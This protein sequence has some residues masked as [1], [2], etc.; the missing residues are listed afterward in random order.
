[1]RHGKIAGMA[2]ALLGT[3]Q[4]TIAAIA[5][6]ALGTIDSST[7]LPMAMVIAGC[8]VAATLLNFLTLGAK[9]DAAPA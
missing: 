7:A 4:F 6:I 8:G 3:N 9:L 1:M 5:T 2:S